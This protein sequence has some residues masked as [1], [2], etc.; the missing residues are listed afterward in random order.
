MNWLDWSWW[1]YLEVPFPFTD[2]GVVLDFTP[3]DDFLTM[4]FSVVGPLLV[5]VAVFLIVR[6]ILVSFS[7]GD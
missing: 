4:V 3:V 5:F 6:R 2:E 1:P 7:G